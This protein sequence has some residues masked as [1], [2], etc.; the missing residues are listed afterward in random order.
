MYSITDVGLKTLTIVLSLGT[1]PAS[2]YLVGDIA[3]NESHDRLVKYLLVGMFVGVTISAA[4]TA[5]INT[6]SLFFGASETSLNHLVNIRNLVKNSTL[7]AISW[8][9]LI[10]TRG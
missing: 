4:L 5:Y 6:Q 7:F 2:I 8:G 1:L 9:F 10:I 3:R